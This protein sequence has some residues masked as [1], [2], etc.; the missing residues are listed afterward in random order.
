MIIQKTKNY[1]L[2]CGASVTTKDLYCYQVVNN[3]WHVTEFETT[4]LPKAITGLIGLQKDLDT[5]LE[6]GS[7]G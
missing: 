4:L 7:D 6:E 2:Q 1:T 5:V 3:D